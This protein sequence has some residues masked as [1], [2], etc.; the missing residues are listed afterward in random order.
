VTFVF[1]LIYSTICS[2]L[3]LSSLCRL[4]ARFVAIG[5]Y[6]C[7]TSQYS[8]LIDL[9]L[10]GS[11]RKCF[12]S[13]HLDLFVFIQTAAYAYIPSNVMQSK[14]LFFDPS[15]NWV[16]RYLLCYTLYSPR[17]LGAKILLFCMILHPQNFPYVQSISLINY[18]ILMPLEF[19]SVDGSSSDISSRAI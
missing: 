12:L 15:V 8:T 7:F 14:P 13:S 1:S 4:D 16:S 3:T 9:Q 5:T 18:R 11:S 10:D 2:G 19:C 17:E 6:C